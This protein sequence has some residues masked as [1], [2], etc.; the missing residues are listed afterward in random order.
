MSIMP[1]MPILTL[2]VVHAVENYAA[3]WQSTTL[4]EIIDHGNCM[5]QKGEKAEW[6][7]CGSDIQGRLGNLMEVILGN[8]LYCQELR[9]YV[10]CQ[11]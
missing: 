5:G 9:V 4:G 3:L 2:G 1:V 6:S 11:T 7:S 10:P 8:P